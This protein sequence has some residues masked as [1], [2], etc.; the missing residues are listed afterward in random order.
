MSEE[1]L[2]R[3]EVAYK[4]DN[5]FNLVFTSK[6]IIVARLSSA[7]LGL[8]E[9]RKRQE[10]YG[11]TSAESILK[12][13]EM[14]FAI[15]YEEVVKVEMKRPST[16]SRGKIKILAISKKFPDLPIAKII[17]PVDVYEFTFKEEKNLFDERVNLVR[18]I[19]P[20]KLSLT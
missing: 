13:D 11:G 1:I 6:R 2:G 7:L 15:P 4:R 16:F 3:I 14:N 18:S 5:L 17:I 20:D 19:L 10:E 8:F 12:A 9:T